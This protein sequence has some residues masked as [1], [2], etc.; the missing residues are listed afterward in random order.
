L[1]LETFMGPDPS[2][3]NHVHYKNGN[4]WD[5]SLKNLEWKS[6]ART[7][8]G[9][10]ARYVS[11]SLS[12]EDMRQLT[13]LKP[14]DATL[15]GFVST[16]LSVGI[17]AV[18][19]KAASAEHEA[20][21]V[22]AHLRELTSP[23]SDDAGPDGTASIDWDAWPT[24]PDDWPS[25]LKGPP[26]DRLEYFRYKGR[27]SEEGLAWTAL[28]KKLSMVDPN[29]TTP[30]SVVEEAAAD[31]YETSERAR[32]RLQGGKNVYRGA[33]DYLLNHVGGALERWEKAQKT[34]ASP[35]TMPEP[36]PFG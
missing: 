30:M 34:S 2:G 29:K 22:V 23:E 31:L 21:A 20:A 16:V 3:S 12:S 24:V 25:I 33:Y 7:I 27:T 8:H 28:Y 14:A 11:V 36:S 35:T 19:G 10:G 1:V 9:N 13:L 18:S 15:E 4:P 26:T 6:V 32:G 5:I 17:K